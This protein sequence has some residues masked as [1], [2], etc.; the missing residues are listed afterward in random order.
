MIRPTIVIYLLALVLASICQAETIEE[1]EAR[2][3]APNVAEIVTRNQ[4]SQLGNCTYYDITV[5]TT[6]KDADV[7]RTQ[8]QPVIKLADGTFRLNGQRV[9]NYVAPIAEP[10]RTPLEA[11]KI[12]VDAA[13]GVGN[14]KFIKLDTNGK[15]TVATIRRKDNDAKLAVTLGGDGTPVTVE[16]E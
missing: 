3:I 14:W 13:L 6:T 15:D 8:T 2:V 11:A 4:V 9:T 5:I 16:A 1:F 10:E 7:V 12:A